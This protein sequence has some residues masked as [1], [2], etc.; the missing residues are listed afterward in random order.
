MEPPWKEVGST[1]KSCAQEIICFTTISVLDSEAQTLAFFVIR[2]VV[3]R[4]LPHWLQRVLLDLRLTP[5]S[6][7]SR[8]FADA[9]RIGAARP[10]ISCTQSF[11][12]EHADMHLHNILKGGLILLLLSCQG[13]IIESPSQLSILGLFPP[14]CK[15]CLHNGSKGA[16]EQ[17]RCIV[18]DHRFLLHGLSSAPLFHVSGD[19]LLPKGECHLVRCSLHTFHEGC[20]SLRC[21]SLSLLPL[22]KYCQPSHEHQ[23][24]TVGIILS[25]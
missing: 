3:L 21:A 10:S 19:V 9:V 7:S 14:S 8:H 11:G 1:Q 2:D 24:K 23:P 5:D 12:V 4:L 22:L 15:D 20:G 18:A 25:E 17:L 6:W 16:H 13:S